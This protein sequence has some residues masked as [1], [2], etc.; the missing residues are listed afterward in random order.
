MVLRGRPDWQ[1]HLRSQSL[2]AS[3]SHGEVGLLG[4][5]SLQPLKAK[6][7]EISQCVRLGRGWLLRLVGGRDLQWGKVLT[8]FWALPFKPASLM[9]REQLGPRQFYSWWIFP[10]LFSCLLSFWRLRVGLR[11]WG[12][13]SSSCPVAQLLK[14]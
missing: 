14:P 4:Y 12:W 5:Q 9:P 8:N 13:I 1:R 10:S 3:W 11:A 6:A 7:Q 2:S